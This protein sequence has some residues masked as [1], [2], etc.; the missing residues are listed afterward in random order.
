MFWCNLWLNG[1]TL[2]IPLVVHLRDKGRSCV[3]G[4]AVNIAWNS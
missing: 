1:T 3:A 2:D 4:G